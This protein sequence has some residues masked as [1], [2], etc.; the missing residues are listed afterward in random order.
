MKVKWALV[1]LLVLALLLSL[2]TVNLSLAQGPEGAGQPQGE[3]AIVGTVGGK[4]SYQGV[5]TENG[6]P[7]N[8]TRDMVFRLYSDSSCATQVGSDIAKNSVQ[9]TDG[10]FHVTLD[11]DQR[12]FNGQALWLEVEVGGTKIGC[13]EILPVPYAL[14]LRP[15]A[16]ISDTDAFV[17]VNYS[18][19]WGWPTPIFMNTYGLYA[20]VKGDATA[21]FYYGVYAS[22]ESDQ[23]YTGAFYNEHTNG[24]ALYARSGSDDAADLIV[25]GNSSTE[26]NGVIRSDPTYSSSDIVLV[27][28]D[29]VRIDLDADKNDSDS[30]FEIYDENGTLI[31]GVDDSGAVTWKA[32]TGYVSVPAA[33]FR[34]WEDGYDYENR[35]R[36]LKN[37]DGNSDN[38]YAPVQLPHGATVTKLT[39]Y[40]ND[41][42]TA[43][44]GRA[45][46][47]R[48]D[49]NGNYINMATATTSGSGGN[50]SS[51]DNTISV[52]SV[53]NSQYAY[54]LWWNLPDSN[55]IGY[56]VVIE[57]TFT[58]P[59]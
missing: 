48:V 35:G 5:L 21:A 15:N 38:Y 1:S 39:F 18:Y 20:K 37:M 54:Y 22:T 29:N 16:V 51:Y 45:V 42:S 49:S 12:N 26:D 41:T 13:Q 36:S 14:S 50:G 34:P 40:W 24:T 59:H 30:D 28:G 2:A 31:F 8:G 58:A 55:V 53:D 10:R 57:Y 23:G 7:V 19:T 52:A 47:R 33:A 27:S 6:Q 32:Q 3:A 11:V 46:L 4:I 9:V 43:N 44:D 25:G 17:G 56:Y